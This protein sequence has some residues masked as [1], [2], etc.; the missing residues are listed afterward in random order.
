MSNIYACIYLLY[1]IG[2]ILFST[3]SELLYTII[4]LAKTSTI[5][6]MYYTPFLLDNRAIT[7]LLG[8]TTRISRAISKL[9][10]LYNYQLYRVKYIYLNCIDLK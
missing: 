6:I 5:C 9:I 2:N 4:I 10:K 7:Y 8:T 3:S 1:T